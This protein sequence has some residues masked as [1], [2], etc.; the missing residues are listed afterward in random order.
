MKSA[1]RKILPITVISVMIAL[2]AMI[3]FQTSFAESVRDV[4]FTVKY[5]QTEAR[6]MTDSVNSFRTGDQAWA[7]N[8][9]GSKVTYSNLQPLKYDYE[10]EKVAMLRAAEL[11]VSYSHTRPNGEQCFTAYPSAYYNTY[12]GENIAIGYST[13]DSVFKAWREDNDDYS[14]QGHRRNMLNQ[15][16]TGIGIGHAV[17]NGT[18]LWVQ[19]FSSTVVDPAGSPANDSNT[20]VTVSATTTLADQFDKNR[21]TEEADEGAIVV[22]KVTGFSVKA[23]KGKKSFTATWK[24]TN[25]ENCGYE[26]QFA[27]KSNFKGAKIQTIRNN[28]ITSTTVKKLKAKKKYYVRIRAF[29]EVDDT[30]YC[31]DWSTKKI[32]TTK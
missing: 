17:Y 23:K 6:A 31:S 26:I 2:I 16:Y 7:W 20:E 14:G 30:K 32:V 18:H 29:C 19:E 24:S 13:G 4:S 12:R 21:P 27:L 22:E 10:L 11:A 25:Q 5:G 9:S 1:T 3:P 28:A 15:N 8:E